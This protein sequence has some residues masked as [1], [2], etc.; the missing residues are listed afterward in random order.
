MK[1]IFRLV[2]V[3]IKK[4]ISLKFVVITLLMFSFIGAYRIS[5]IESNIG[6]LEFYS[7]S[8]FTSLNSFENIAEVFIWSL[9]QFLF[10]AHVSKFIG[11][12]FTIGN[13]FYISRAGNK[14]RWLLGIEWTIFIVSIIYHF[15]SL[16]IFY[17]FCVGF[18]NLVMTKVTYELFLLVLL[19]GLSSL[20]YSN[21]YI[22]LS[23]FLKKNISALLYIIFSIYIS[24]YMGISMDINKLLPFNQILISHISSNIS[25]LLYANIYLLL[26]NIIVFAIYVRYILKNDLNKI[27]Q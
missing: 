27:I 7:Y 11:N 15:S 14:V 21:I 6:F 9:Y 3:N 17:I 19:L 2:I 12:E 25:S 13:I 4:I 20:L 18:T 16:L 26:F 8:F 22:C 5:S 24:L 1:N 10:I 23:T